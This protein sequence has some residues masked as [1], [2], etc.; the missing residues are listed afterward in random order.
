MA[1]NNENLKGILERKIL[2]INKIK[3]NV[4]ILKFE[5]QN[6]MKNYEETDKNVGFYDIFMRIFTIFF[7]K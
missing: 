7:L 6:M 3:E 1:I 5:N 2:E 4:D